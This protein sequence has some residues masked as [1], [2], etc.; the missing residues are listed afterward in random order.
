MKKNILIIVSIFC[1]LFSEAQVLKLEEI[2]KGNDFIGNLP[3]NE[4]WS[5]DGTTIYFDWNPNKEWGNSTYFWKKGMKV[6]QKASKEEAKFSKFK[7][8]EKEGT[9]IYYYMD[10]GQIFSYSINNKRVKKIYQNNSPVSN[11]QVGK[12][13]GVVFF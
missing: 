10:K 4:R 1:S 8:I 2:M 12:E 11:L 3:E 6:P 9:G 5:L 7:F 13:D